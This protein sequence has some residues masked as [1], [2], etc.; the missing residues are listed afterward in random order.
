MKNPLCQMCQRREVDC[1]RFYR[2]KVEQCDDFL[3]FDPDV[4]VLPT[5]VEATEWVLSGT[6]PTAAPTIT[7]EDPVEQLIDAPSPV[8]NG[9]S[10]RQVI[11]KWLIVSVLVFIFI[12]GYL[13][14]KTKI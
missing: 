7:D 14:L 8:E 9:P 4:P 10:R 13:L 12:V 2:E 11:I 5:Q 6:I 3:E 1:G